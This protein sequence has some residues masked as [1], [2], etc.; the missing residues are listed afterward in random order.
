[1]NWRDLI[2]HNLWW[3]VFSLLIAVIVWS[4]YHISGGTFSIGAL[5]EDTTQ[6]V[7]PN[8]R[9]RIL[10]RQTDLHRYQIRPEEVT[11]TV[12]GR[13]DAVLTMNIRDIAVYVDMQ[14]YVA[15]ET[16]LLPVQIRTPPGIKVSGV[17]P[18]RVQAT[19][20]EPEFMPA[21]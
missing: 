20:L 3:K 1:M 10:T 16:N 5:Y 21:D 11:V 15:G 12:S 13:R 18:E 6:M 14:E 17:I 19:R 8:Y 4:T 7:F 2:F 9:P